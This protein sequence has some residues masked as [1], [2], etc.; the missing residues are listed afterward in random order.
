MLPRIVMLGPKRLAGNALKMSFAGDRTIELFKG[1]MPRRNEIGSRVSRDIF[2]VS[3][4]DEKTDPSNFNPAS[5][6]EKWAAVEVENFDDIPEEMDRLELPGGLYALF[7][8]KGGPA[9]APRTF[10]FIFGTWLPGCDY[11]VDKRP[12]FEILGEKYG[13]GGADS[14]EEIWLPIKPK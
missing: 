13:D 4:Y 6:F 11:S 3:I 5:I 7:D 14:E 9:A 1:F 8:H 10:G 2:C 12:H